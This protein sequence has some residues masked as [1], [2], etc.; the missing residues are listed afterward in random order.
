MKQTCEKCDA[1]FVS[2]DFLNKHIAKVHA[3]S[4]EKP[5]PF[6]KVA[7]SQKILENFYPTLRRD[8]MESQ[9]I[10]NHKPLPREATGS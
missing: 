6:V 8:S 2:E 9:K 3:K 4:V 1:T 5:K 10:A 7:L